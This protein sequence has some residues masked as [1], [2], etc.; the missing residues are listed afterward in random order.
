M[1]NIG[2]EAIRKK[3]KHYAEDDVLIQVCRLKSGKHR[4][5]RVRRHKQIY[6]GIARAVE[7]AEIRKMQQSETE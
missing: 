3:G 2:L 6:N 1:K 4:H 7:K 5:R